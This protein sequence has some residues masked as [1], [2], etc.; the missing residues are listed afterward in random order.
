[1]LFIEKLGRQFI[2]VW[3]FLAIISLMWLMSM[4]IYYKL[5]WVAAASNVMIS[6]FMYFSVVAMFFVWPNEIAQPFAVG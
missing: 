6:F 2:L 4:A 1:V 3:G 5:V